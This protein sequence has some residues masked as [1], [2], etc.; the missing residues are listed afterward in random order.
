VGVIEGFR[1]AMI[2]GEPPETGLLIVSFCISF[3]IFLVGYGLFKLYEFRLA[4]VI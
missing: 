3:F 4:D 1:S 2:K